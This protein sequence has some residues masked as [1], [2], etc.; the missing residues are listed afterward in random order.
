[1]EKATGEHTDANRDWYGL[2]SFRSFASLTKGPQPRFGCE[3]VGPVVSVGPTTS[4]PK[5]VRKVLDGER[6]GGKVAYIR[7][8]A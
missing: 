1:M 6:H 8:T 7:R 2:G 5:C 3:P 4:L